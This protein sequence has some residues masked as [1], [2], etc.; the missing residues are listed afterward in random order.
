VNPGVSWIACS[1]AVA[2]FFLPSTEGE[3]RASH[4]RLA[5]SG[6]VKGKELAG[7][8]KAGITTTKALLEQGAT[9]KARRRMAKQSA[10]AMPRVLG[11]VEACDL[12]RIEGVGPTMVRLFQA[13]GYRH[14]AKFRRV[15][16]ATVWSKIVA[17]NTRLKLV[18]EP[19][20]KGLVA[21]WVRAAQSMKSVVK[22]LK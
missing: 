21:R 18:P 4:Y 3:A 1:A 20:A 7:L 16:S 14:T 19:P 11:L 17:A 15:K 12:L 10:I 5:G 9:Q 13:S 6:L 2:I 8:K 22:G